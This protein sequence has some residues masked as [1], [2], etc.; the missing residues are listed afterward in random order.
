VLDQLKGLDSI[1]RNLGPRVEILNPEAEPIKA[2][3]AQKLEHLIGGFTRIQLDGE[4][5]RLVYWVPVKVD[6][7]QIQ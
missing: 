1:D 3:P 2:S 4:L 7:D 6:R 5:A